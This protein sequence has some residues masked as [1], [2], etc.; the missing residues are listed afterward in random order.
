MVAIIRNSVNESQFLRSLN[1][2]AARTL[3]NPRPPTPGLVYRR[4]L[5]NRSTLGPLR[6]GLNFLHSALFPKP[7]DWDYRI[8][9]NRK[10]QTLS[11]NGTSALNFQCSVF[12]LPIVFA[13]H[14]FLG[15][16]QSLNEERS[17]ETV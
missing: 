17:P 1:P 12:I 5:H 16:S 10:K 11:K 6:A 13:Q 15:P 8:R 2:P 3:V 9:D 7:L 14:L 4:G